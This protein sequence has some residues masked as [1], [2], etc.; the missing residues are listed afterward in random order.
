TNADGSKFGKTV[1]GAIWLDPKRTSVYRFYQFWIRTDDR[2]V[3]RMLKYF[4]FLSQEDIAML[5]QEHLAKPEARVAH[6]ALAKSATDLIHGLNATQEAMRASEILFGG[7][8]EGISEIT[9]NDIVGEV[10]T[11]P[12]EAIKFEGSGW[13]LIDALVHAGLASSK[14][15][16]RKD[17]EGGGIYVNNSREVSLTRAL[18][19][20]DLLFSKHI[21][22]RKGK[23]NYV[24][25]SVV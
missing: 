12:F 11:K 17:I 9:F 23:R 4:T 2:D 25:L 16:A 3:V 8:L 15:Q 5:E 18:G 10:P 19:A 20:N 21:L 13:P 22:I 14:G 6:K 24:V 7:E 1:A